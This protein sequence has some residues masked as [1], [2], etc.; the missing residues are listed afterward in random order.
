M[1]GTERAECDQLAEYM[2]EL[3]PALERFSTFDGPDFAG[4]ERARWRRLLDQ[5]LPERAHGLKAVVSDLKAIVIPNGLRVGAPGFAGWVATAPTTAGTIASLAATVS[6]THRYFLTAY[7]S[8]ETIALRWLRELLGLDSKFQGL[9]VSGGATANLVALGAARQHAFEQLGVDPARDGMPDTRRWRIYASSE[10]HHSIFRA[11]GILGIG[12]SNVT[13]IPVDAEMRIDLRALQEALDRDAAARLIPVALVANAGTTNTGAVDPIAEM[14]A[15]ARQRKIWLHVDGAYGLFGRL[16]TRVQ[17]LFDGVREADSVITDP[18]KWLAAPAGSG[19]VFV[20][21]QALQERA[22]TME[23]A[24]YAEGAMVAGEI[25][26]T[27][28]SLGDDYLQLGPEMS[29][30]SRGV[31]VWAVLKE[32]GAEGV[33]ERVSRHCSFARRVFELALADERLEPLLRPTLSICC[34]RYYAPN[35]SEDGLDELN[36]EIAQRLRVEGIVPSITRVRGKYAIRPCFINPRTT[37]TDVER[38][39]ARTRAIGDELLRAA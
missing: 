25:K 20:R 12:R 30:P 34:Y 16:D 17:S 35:M 24:D 19:A 38:M 22:F 28:D 11:A 2:G 18:H 31:A 32:I 27:F 21:D 10:A 33:R 4:P 14:V 23:P 26:S 15:I 3:L 13:Q 39:V 29:A 36:T 37:I 1:D 9:F 5:P 7:N 8:L 6:G